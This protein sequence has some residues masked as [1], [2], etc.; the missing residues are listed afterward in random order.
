VKTNPSLFEAAR[1]AAQFFFVILFVFL[2]AGAARAQQPSQESARVAEEVKRTWAPLRERTQE[3]ARAL[4]TPQKD[5]S[6][7]HQNLGE[8]LRSEPTEANLDAIDALLGGMIEKSDAILGHRGKANRLFTDL[9]RGLGD[10]EKWTRGLAQKGETSV[11][12]NLQEMREHL[13][14]LYPELPEH[15]KKRYA[16]LYE[17]ILRTQAAYA[18]LGLSILKGGS[19]DL[20]AR[21][22]EQV[23]LQ[24]VAYKGLFESIEGWKQSYER[25]RVLLAQARSVGE[26]R[27]TLG[28]ILAQ[29][30]A[31]GGGPG[32]SVDLSAL[33][34]VVGSILSPNG[35]G[36]AELPKTAA[37]LEASMAADRK[38]S[39]DAKGERRP[40]L[41]QRSLISTR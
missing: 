7:Q 19:G 39:I 32:G 29:L 22:R 40:L 35:E 21:V 10:T 4:E 12:E 3:L 38:R 26:V 30:E 13:A 34:D 33:P 2:A 17:Q 16:A 20:L 9:G 28:S 14:A 27:S 41:G 8:R 24:R 31:E 18:G 6:Q 5:L 1:G 11:L 36:A 25:A 23:D 37:D 15:W